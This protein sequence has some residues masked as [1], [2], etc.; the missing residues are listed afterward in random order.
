MVIES[1]GNLLR[2]RPIELHVQFASRGEI[3]FPIRIKGN[4]FS[5]S[6]NTIF[7]DAQGRRLKGPIS[8]TLDGERVLP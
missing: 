1:A 4:G 8:A 6:A 5:G 3:S 7:Y 2:S